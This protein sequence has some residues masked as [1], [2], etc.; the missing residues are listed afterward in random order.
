MLG[1]SPVHPDKN[2]VIPFAPEPILKGDSIA[3]NDC[4]HNA[5]KRL[6]EDLRR[7]HPH[8]KLLIIE[9]ALP[10][11]DPHLSMDYSIG[12]RPGDHAYLFDWIKALSGKNYT[13]TDNKG[14]RHD[15][16]FYHDAPLNDDH[17]D[18]LKFR[19]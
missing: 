2:V 7:E 13:L 14:M 5:S 1:I 19:S 10:S 6:L 12:V 17:H 16:H 18:Y 8:L 11:N 3:K 9:D 15:F 4:E